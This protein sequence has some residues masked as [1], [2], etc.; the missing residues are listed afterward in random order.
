MRKYEINITQNNFIYEYPKEPICT[1][2]LVNFE[3]KENIYLNHMSIIKGNKN[4]CP[5]HIK[6]LSAIPKYMIDDKNSF[7]N[8]TSR[9]FNRDC[10]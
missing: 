2:I 10:F 9:L 3:V 5:K 8:N 4:G 1:W 6:I 7:I